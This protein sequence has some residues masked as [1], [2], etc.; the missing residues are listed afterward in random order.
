MLTSVRNGL[1]LIL[2]ICSA[3][4][5]AE[6]WELQLFHDKDDSVLNIIDI[7]F[8]T[9]QRGLAVAILEEKGR[10]KPT[11]LVTSN[12]GADWEYVEAP[13]APVSLY[14][15][16]E[17]ACWMVG[18]KGVWFT[19]EGGRQWNRVLKRS[20][21]TK[22]YFLTR[23]RGWAIGAEKTLLA[24][25]DGGKKWTKMPVTEE[26]KTSEDRTVFHAISFFGKSGVIAGRSEPVSRSELPI[27]MDP[28]IED[29]KERPT[30]TVVLQ[31]QD[32]GET[33]KVST[34]SIFG[35]ISDVA[36]SDTGLGLALIEFD[37]WFEYP[38]EIYVMNLVTGKNDRVLRQTNFA[39][40]DVVVLS[41]GAG[42][43]AGFVPAGKLAQTPIPGKLRIL[44]SNNLINWT[45]M[46]IDYRAVARRASLAFAG[47]EHGWVA[48]DTGMILHLARD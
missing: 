21:L 34:T 25:T 47:R 46:E 39:A 18:R 20:N 40:T 7:A 13:D 9:P 48:T 3:S 31:T 43:V 6:R 22:V 11:T 1:F 23:E 27:W 44:T 24:T 16:D 29:R 15:L 28:D 2:A 5:A 10:E 38:S 12:G 19:S 32:S 42:V 17:S 35:R 41:S 30:M 26:V 37:R 8:P 33:W 36:T 14:C 4:G 45:D